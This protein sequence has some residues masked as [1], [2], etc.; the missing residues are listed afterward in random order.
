MDDDPGERP[1]AIG[2]VEPAV[3]TAALIL[4]G[5]RPWWLPPMVSPES[6]RRG[7]LGGMH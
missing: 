2:P 1:E 7:V 5:Y 4:A 3:L 6:I